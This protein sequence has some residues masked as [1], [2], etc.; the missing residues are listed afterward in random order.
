M[1][2]VC[3]QDVPL[4]C[5]E[6]ILQSD[7]RRFPVYTNLEIRDDLEEIFVPDPIV[8]P[9]EGACGIPDLARIVVYTGDEN[10]S[11]DMCRTTVAPSCE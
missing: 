7:E 10:N 5:P 4:E 6:A 8:V 3:Q 9:S 11:D 2:V 1:V